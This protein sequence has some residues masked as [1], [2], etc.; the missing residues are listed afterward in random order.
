MRKVTKPKKDIVLNT[1]GK[2]IAWHRAHREMTQAELAAMLFIKREH[3]NMIENDKR[4]PTV[5]QIKL[6]ADALDLTTDYLLCRI[7][8]Q[9]KD[10]TEQAIHN[11]LGLTAEAIRQLEFDRARCQKDNPE[12]FRILKLRIL[13][14]LIVED[15][16]LYKI[17][18]YF[19]IPDDCTVS[20]AY[21]SEDVGDL[22]MGTLKD[23][24][25]LTHK[26]KHFAQVDYENLLLLEIQKMLTEMKPRLLKLEDEDELLKQL[27]K[28]ESEGI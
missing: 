6:L 11:K 4:T 20:I 3:F 24:K 8:D 1:T 10:I 18:K 22:L 21:K 5:E 12:Y 13:N 9:T 14:F 16:L 2:R 23:Y 25:T 19:H 15:G 27:D 28:K 7:S 26:Y 17:A